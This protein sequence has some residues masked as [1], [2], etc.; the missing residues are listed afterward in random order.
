LGG[1]TPGSID[2]CLL[3][4]ELMETRIDEIADDI[5]R[6]STLVPDIAPPAGYTF[7]QFLV[8]GEEPLLFHTGL[9]RMFPLIRPAVARLVAPERLRCA[10]LPVT[11]TAASS[12]ACRGPWLREARP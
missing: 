3:V 7:N 2:I 10:I 4:E 6:L 1:H 11:T 9:R 12:S 5:Y 8:L